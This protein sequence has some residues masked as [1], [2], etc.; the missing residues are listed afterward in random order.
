MILLLGWTRLHPELHGVSELQTMSPVSQNEP[1]SDE[2][3]VFAIAGGDRDALGELYDRHAGAVAAVARR[4]GV[5]DDQLEE[6]V[7]DVF[8]ELWGSAGEYDP[9][10]ASVRTWLL[11]RTRS[12]AID[13]QRKRTRRQELLDQSGDLLHPTSPAIDQAKAVAHEQVRQAVARLDEELR[14]VVDLAYFAGE[15]TRSMAEALGI[16]R[17]TVKSRLRRAREAVAALLT[18]PS[19]GGLS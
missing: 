14:Q 2:E 13:R 5:G 11:V 1:E 3:L 10:R 18:D 19:G 17:G 8:L 16:P 12:R 15:S 9:E 4:Y 6:L 7:H